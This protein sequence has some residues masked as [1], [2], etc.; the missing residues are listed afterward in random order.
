MRIIAGIFKGKKIYSVEGFTARP[1]T[2]FIREM[3][4]STLMSIEPKM[5]KVLDLFAGSGSL[6]FEALSRGVENVT[7]VEASKKSVS[8]I[9][10]NIDLLK[11]SD[12]CKVIMKK[13][14]SFLKSISEEKFNI[15]FADPPYDKGLVNITLSIIKEKEIL[16]EDGIIVFEH[17]KNEPLS[18]EYK[19]FVFKEKSSGPTI[20]S[21]INFRSFYVNL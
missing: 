11:S 14:D 15:I 21:F 2:D 18:E 8:T 3:M 9:I 13:V 17:S 5:N 12:K 16:C 1:T 10:S 19:K 4:F 6:G 7:F 20:I